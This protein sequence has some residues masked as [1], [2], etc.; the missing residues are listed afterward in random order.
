M[1]R[2]IDLAFF[3]HFLSLQYKF[4]LLG[5]LF[6]FCSHADRALEDQGRPRTSL[7]PVLDMKKKLGNGRRRSLIRREAFSFGK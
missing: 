3:L 2:K 1:K 4:V 5:R 6:S 7:Y